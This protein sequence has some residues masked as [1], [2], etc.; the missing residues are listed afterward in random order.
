MIEYTLM[1]HQLEAVE[2]FKDE[3]YGALFM[4]MGTGKTLTVFEITKKD[5][6]ILFIT[7]K[8]VIPD[9]LRQTDDYTDKT[10]FVLTSKSKDLGVEDGKLKYDMYVTNYEFML[11]NLKWVMGHR[12]AAVILDESNSIKTSTA[13]RT[14]NCLL[15]RS[16][17]GRRF[18]LTGTP[19]TRGYEDLFTQFKFLENEI[20]PKYKTTFKNQYCVMQQ[21]WNKSGKQFPIIAGYKNIFESQEEGIV[22][23]MQRILPHTFT[24]SKKECLDLPE[25]TYTIEQVEMNAEI[26]K[27][28]KSVKTDLTLTLETLDGEDDTLI[29][30]NIFSKIAK[31]HQLSNWFL[32]S[33]DSDEVHRF[34]DNPKIKWLEEN[35]ADMTENGNKVILFYKFRETG[36]QV[37]NMI[38]KMGI[39]YVQLH[40]DQTIDERG[41]LLKRFQTE[42]AFK[43][44][45]CP[46]S[47]GSHGI[48]A[49]A[50]NYCV[51]LNCDDDF[52][53]RHQSESRLHRIGQTRNVH[54]VDLVT[55]DSLEINI[56]RR[57]KKK[58]EMLA[59]AV[60][61]LE[62]RQKVVD[63]IK[64]LIM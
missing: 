58:K 17:A 43:I 46:I 61:G 35:L 21:M 24:A 25:Q 47:I 56:L 8:T 14:K 50:A 41:G 23:L 39:K 9:I 48:T 57:N 28:Y 26:K 19:L 7:K 12:W 29:M 34:G 33:Q 64:D 2:K 38:E 16:L 3:N 60:D 44:F 59:A 62:R 42:D 15:L 37:K 55:K 36:V 30:E 52:G 49:T 27:M 53:A 6:P 20:L 13:Q 51:Y 63:D 54:Y 22:P 31:L 4:E 10:A 11:H 18:I 5:T 1:K 45:A 40:S 32:Y